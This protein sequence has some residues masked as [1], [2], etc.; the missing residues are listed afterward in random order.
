M[1]EHCISQVVATA[2]KRVYQALSMIT[3]GLL[4]SCQS[5]II[6]YAPPMTPQQRAASIAHTNAIDDD[7]Y[8]RRDRERQSAARAIERA[9]R[10]NPTHVSNTYAP[11][12]AP[13]YSRW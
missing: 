1:K 9:T 2:K 8:Y 4:V 12:Y 7:D 5:P 3:L 11:T 6:G 13:S 10:H